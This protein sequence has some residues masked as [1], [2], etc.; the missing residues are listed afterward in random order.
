MK[1]SKM[2]SIIGHNSDIR[3]MNNKLSCFFLL[4]FIFFI[5][6]R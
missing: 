4:F 3:V 6:L 5:K 2:E 1:K